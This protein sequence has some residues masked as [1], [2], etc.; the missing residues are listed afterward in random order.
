[1]V[2]GPGDVVYALVGAANDLRLYRSDD[3]GLTF[4]PKVS[5]SQG[6]HPKCWPSCA[7]RWPWGPMED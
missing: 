3:S 5:V 1:M 7:R 4:G 2:A 6:T